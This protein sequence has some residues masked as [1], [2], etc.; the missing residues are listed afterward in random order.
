MGLKL[1]ILPS[2]SNLH[3]TDAILLEHLLKIEDIVEVHCNFKFRT[4]KN[5]FQKVRKFVGE[6]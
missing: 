6:I 5:T 4:F 1:F 3:P 2:G